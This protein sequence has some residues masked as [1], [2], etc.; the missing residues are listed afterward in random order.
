MGPQCPG[1]T[2]STPSV[3]EVVVVSVRP[4]RPHPRSG[5]NPTLHACRV[6]WRD[7]FHGCQCAPRITTVTSYRLNVYHIFIFHK[8]QSPGHAT[9]ICTTVS[10]A[11]RLFSTSISAWHKDFMWV[12]FH[13]AQNRVAEI[14]SRYMLLYSVISVA[15]R[16]HVRGSEIE[17]LD[18]IHSSQPIR[19]GFAKK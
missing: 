1:G 13:R 17:H 10:M 8:F 5:C 19:Q 6:H 16:G 2:A 4:G 9:V 18:I 11:V 7:G 3:T 14:I 12:G 15:Y